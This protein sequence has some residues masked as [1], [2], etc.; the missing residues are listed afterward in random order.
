MGVEYAH[1]TKKKKS[2]ENLN[3]DLFLDGTLEEY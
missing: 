2:F 3:K 1:K